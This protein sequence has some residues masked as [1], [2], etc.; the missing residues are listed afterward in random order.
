[1]DRS[2]QLM[3]ALQS[4]IGLR[5]GATQ[6]VEAERIT[7]EMD[8]PL[9]KG[10][11]CPFRMEL[12][13]VEDTVMGVIRIDRVLPKRQGALP[14]F[15]ARIIEMPEADRRT[16]DGW[17]RDQATGGISRRMERDPDAIRQ[18][19]TDQMRG[20]TD[21]EARV[22][23]EKMNAKSIYKRKSKDRIEGDPFGLGNESSDGSRA[24]QD[25]LRDKIRASAQAMPTQPPAAQVPAAEP[26]PPE[27]EASEAWT[28]KDSTESPPEWL[29]PVQETEVTSSNQSIEWLHESD[30]A[31]GHQAKPEPEST[32]TGFQAIT[33]EPEPEPEPED[34]DPAGVPEAAQEGTEI[35]TGPTIE[36]QSHQQPIEISV[37]FSTAEA[38]A[39]EYQSSLRSSAMTVQHPAL[40]MLYLPVAITLTLPDNQALTCMGQTVART[41]QG[42]AI[43][44]E[45]D[46]KQ[47]KILADMAGD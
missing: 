45:L 42:T 34:T 43:A 20:A 31:P 24:N 12:T 41:S 8:V 15:I 19:M 27:P 3:F 6:G 23:L 33:P 10:T 30:Q 47:R 32:Y 22:V 29:R 5:F 28:P 17:R 46:G 37:T 40:E 44:L 13:G 11:T 26:A 7:F 35:A 4:P 38:L 1:M 21:A 14:R 25:A 9:E 2:A 36:V 16:F 18:A 39:A